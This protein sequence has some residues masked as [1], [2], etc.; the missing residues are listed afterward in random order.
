MSPVLI[1]FLTHT[2]PALLQQV[3]GLLLIVALLACLSWIIL[4]LS[5][6]LLIMPVIDPTRLR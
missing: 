2:N 1:A 5:I 6:G 3:S 4:S